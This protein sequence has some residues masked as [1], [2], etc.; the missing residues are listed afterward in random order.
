MRIRLALVSAAIAALLVFVAGL[1]SAEAA[2]VTDFPAVDMSAPG[3]HLLQFVLANPD[4]TIWFSD[5]GTSGGIGH[6]KLTGAVL[7]AIY[8]A[9]PA[10]DMAIDSSNFVYWTQPSSGTVHR[11]S[12]FGTVDSGG[13]SDYTK[14]SVAIDPVNGARFGGIWVAGGGFQALCYESFA[15]SG[16]CSGGG[17][18]GTLSALTGLTFGPDGKFWAASFGDDR[19]LRMK[20][21]SATSFTTDLVVQLTPGAGPYRIANGADGNLWVT[22]SLSGGIERVDPAGNHTTFPLP[23]NSQPRGITSG[24]GGAMWFTEAGT[25]KIGCITPTG[26]V[27]DFDIPT[28]NSQPWG[29]TT[30]ADGALWFAESSSGKIGRLVPS[31]GCHNPLHDDKIAPVFTSRLALSHK[32]FRVGRASTPLVNLARVTPKGTT[33][34]YSLSESAR[35]TIAVDQRRIGRRVKGKCVKSAH[36]NRAGKRCTYYRTLNNFSR[37]ATAGKN[38]LAFSGRLGS[39]RLAVGRYRAV[40]TAVDAAGNSSLPS[41]A[42]FKIVN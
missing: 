22:D 17:V 38:V 13:T 27:A 29:I 42:A 32:T 9:A 7:P 36:K 34:A 21:N 23:A 6:V 5:G 8:A 14:Y 19:L 24:P 10:L 39:K 4:G 11:R 18:S 20:V 30:G 26:T 12:S 31:E 35:V 40:A 37:T 1:S 16:G 28:P 33:F 2:T 25:N 3:A 15:G 41:R